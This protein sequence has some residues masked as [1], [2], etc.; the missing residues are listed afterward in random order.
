VSAL[1]QWKKDLRLCVASPFYFI[2]CESRESNPDALR[3]WI[4]RLA[5][6]NSG[7]IQCTLEI[8][9][10]VFPRF[11]M[12][13]CHV[14]NAL[15]LRWSQMGN[16]VPSCPQILGR[17]TGNAHVRRLDDW[18]LH[19]S[20]VLLDNLRATK[21]QQT[22]GRIAQTFGSDGQLCIPG[23]IELRATHKTLEPVEESQSVPGAGLRDLLVTWE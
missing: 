18:P 16:A 22:V 1:S 20:H 8:R 2:R 6:P 11:R 21:T 10:K 9:R 17:V 12:K 7:H 13:S 5:T 4:L 19:L 23:F 3:H 15:Y 14:Q